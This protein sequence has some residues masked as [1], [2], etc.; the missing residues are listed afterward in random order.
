MEPHLQRSVLILS[1][2]TQL[3]KAYADE[4][5]LPRKIGLM[6][7]FCPLVVKSAFSTVG[8]LIYNVLSVFFINLT[9]ELLIILFFFKCK[10]QGISNALNLDFVGYSPLNS[11]QSECC[12][13]YVLIS[14][15]NYKPL[16]SYRPI[17][18]SYCVDYP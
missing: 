14:G 2:T 4:V 1:N 17:C 18:H 16:F 7:A 11:I 15:G 9:L 3:T 8:I 13:Y 10:Y 12:N 5:L 6:V